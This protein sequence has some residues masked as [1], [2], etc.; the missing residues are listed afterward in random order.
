MTNEFVV[1]V[2]IA[3]DIVQQHRVGSDRFLG[4]VR[5]P[6]CIGNKLAV[7]ISILRFA[8]QFLATTQK[9]KPIQTTSQL[10]AHLACDVRFSFALLWPVRIHRLSSDDCVKH[11]GDIWDQLT[12]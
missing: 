6:L 2:L 7:I 3:L 12:N 10:T 9:A 8:V 1:L 5:F 4:I 11:G